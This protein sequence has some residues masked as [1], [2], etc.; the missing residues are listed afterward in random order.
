MQGET[1]FISDLHLDTAYPDIQMQFLTFLRQDAAGSDAL[2][3]LGDLFEVWLGDDDDNPQ[4]QQT[5]AALNTL[6]QQTPVFIQHGNRDFLLGDI[7]AKNCNA[8]LLPDPAKIDLYGETVLIMHGDL[9]CTD[10][11]DYQNFR[12]QVRNPAWQQQVLQQPLSQRRQLAQSLRE[13]SNKSTQ[14]K[15]DDIMDV[16]EDTVHS[17]LNDA[18]VH[19]LIHGHTHRP[20]IHEFMLKNKKAKRIVLGDWYDQGSVLR[21]SHDGFRLEVLERSD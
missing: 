5:I 12:K 19:T 7:F 18:S 2:Y 17:Y 21:Y 9:L 16:N 14:Q 8:T 11:T 15:A 3:I 6:S 1:L 20:A 10:D 13:K 4:H